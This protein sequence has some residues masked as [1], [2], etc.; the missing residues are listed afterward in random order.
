M[1]NGKTD[2]AAGGQWY[3]DA[4]TSLYWTWDPADLITQKINGLVPTKGLGG[5]F[6]WSLAQDS[7]DWSRLTAMRE[8]FNTLSGQSSGR[9]KASHFKKHQ[10]HYGHPSY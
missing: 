2:T 7:Q 5:I 8:G 10:G 4:T 3:W 9:P 1:E 6:A